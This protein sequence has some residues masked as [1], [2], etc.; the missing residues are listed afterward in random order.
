MDR[1][2]SGPGDRAVARVRAI[3]NERIAWAD[4]IYPSDE[5]RPL[6][7]RL[8][9]ELA[10]DVRSQLASRR[11]ELVAPRSALPGEP[12]LVADA[13]LIDADARMLGLGRDDLK[14][15]SR[16]LA[17]AFVDLQSFRPDAEAARIQ[18][19]PT[20]AVDE[21]EA[22]RISRAAIIGML[23]ADDMSHR[24]RPSRIGCRRAISRAAGG[25]IAGGCRLPDRGD[26]HCGR[27]P[28]RWSVRASDRARCRPPTLGPWRK[29]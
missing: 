15:A 10:A 18:S 20:G 9:A 8:A 5:D 12:E 3:D 28:H 1:I 2:D 19:D 23:R 17:E 7:G 14:A 21:L 11:G 29:R 25:R 4:P 6:D 27:H 26:D 13:L 22:L 24:R 16:E